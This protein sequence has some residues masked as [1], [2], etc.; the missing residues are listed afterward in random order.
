[1]KCRHFGQL[2]VLLTLSTQVFASS[3]RPELKRLSDELNYENC[4]DVTSSISYLMNGITASGLQDE[5]K[6]DRHE[7]ILSDLWSTKINL[8]ERLRS[9]HRVGSLTQSCADGMRKAF[10]GIRTLEDDVEENYLRS[11]KGSVVFSDNAFEPGNPHLRRHPEFLGFDMMKDLKSGDI[12]L[13]RGKAYTSAAISQLGDFDTQFSHLSV[14]YKDPQGK[15]WTV[16]AHIEVG[17]FVRPLEEHIEDKNFRSAVYRFDDEAIAAKA[18]ELIFNKVKT[19]SDTTGNILYDFGFDLDENKKL[20]CSEI[21]SLAYSVASNGKINLPLFRSKVLERKPEFVKQLGISV[22]ES[23][24]PA[25][26]EVD[27]RFKLVSE[28]R[29]ANII[30]DI[31]EKDAVLQAMFKWSDEEGYVLRQGSSGKSFLYRNI[32][33]PLRRVPYLKKYF[34]EKMPIN[35]TRKLIGYFGV[36][37]SIGKHL[38]DKLKVENEASR[39]ERNVSLTKSEKY[40]V[41]LKVK[42][43]DK[44]KVK[45]KLHHMFRPKK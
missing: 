21:A 8:H 17:S 3:V 27:P 10:I 44:E 18:A 26:L 33:W 4:E 23:F 31:Q 39:V 22:K 28:F 12:I 43:A 20:F 37:E 16:E 42:E 29:N 45:P 35:M 6:S 7:N 32:A 41:L 19:A 14:V 30:N 11:S 9:F 15:F 1:M 25:D 34:I 38:Q 2:L 24:I 40:E 13:S 36:L 5:L